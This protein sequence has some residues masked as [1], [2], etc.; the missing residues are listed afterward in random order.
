MSGLHPFEQAQ[1][2]LN[3]LRVTGHRTSAAN[4]DYLVRELSSLAH[5][6]VLENAQE[7][8]RTEGRRTYYQQ[9]L[10]RP[11]EPAQ[12][13]AIVH[14]SK[15]IAKKKLEESCPSECAICQETPKYKDALCTECDHYYC[16]TCWQT[17]IN[18]P[19]SNRC[20]PTCRAETPKTTSFRARGSVV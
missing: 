2:L 13:T 16:L 12:H 20:C 7:L 8:S 4:V 9:T 3:T 14:K 6:M 5:R 11:R 15:V 1:Q 18:T 17:W 10:V 19:S